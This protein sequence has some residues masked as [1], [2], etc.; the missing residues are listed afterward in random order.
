M[1]VKNS[2]M[3]G[4]RRGQ[5]MIR[6]PSFAPQEAGAITAR[7]ALRPRPGRRRGRV[8]LPAGGGYAAPIHGSEDLPASYERT[9][10]RDRQHYNH[11]LGRGESKVE[12]L[13]RAVKRV[14]EQLQW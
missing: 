10:R 13:L 6:C 9:I 4:K 14:N 3:P 1:Q 2:G 8:S 11:M 7:Q 12:D 5:R